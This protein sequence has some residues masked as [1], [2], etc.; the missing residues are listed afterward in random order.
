MVTP[1]VIGVSLPP[2][3]HTVVAEYRSTPI[4][5]PLLLIGALVLAAAIVFRRRIERLDAQ[6]AAR[7]AAQ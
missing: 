6:L 7:W 1:S 3:R 5:T 4:K 2:G